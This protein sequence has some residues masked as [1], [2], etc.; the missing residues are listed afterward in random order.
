MNFN[1]ILIVSIMIIGLLIFFTVIYHQIN[2]NLPKFID[3]FN[4]HLAIGCDDRVLFDPNDF[5][6]TCNFRNRWTEIRTEYMN[7]SWNRYI[8]LYS[9]ISPD[10]SYCDRSKGWNAVYLR[11][12]NVD[13][14]IA[15]HFPL[16]MNLI[17]QLPCTTAF[18]SILKPHTKLDPHIGVYKGVI[19]YHLGLIIPDDSDNCFLQINDRKISWVEGEDI[20]FDDMYL[21]HVENNTD[22][23]RVILFLDVQRKFEDLFTN[24]LNS[25]FI[26]F[27][28][29]NDTLINTVNN[30]NYYNR[31]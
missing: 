30:V 19:R 11:A 18:F 4:S 21:H 8:P 10:V 29:T 16:T 12:F 6:W 14:D 31:D 22:Q 23:T 26:R 9:Q 28:Q 15:K 5:L 17:E 13:T 7:Y 25:L 24:T 2:D 27:A 1:T 3:M 20:M